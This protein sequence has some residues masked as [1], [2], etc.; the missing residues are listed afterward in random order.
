MRCLF[1]T[2]FAVAA[3]ASLTLAILLTLLW[4]VSPRPLLGVGGRY[5]L[6]VQP[7]GFVFHMYGNVPYVGQSFGPST[8]WA[9]GPLFYLYAPSDPGQFERYV[10]VSCWAVILIFLVLP[11]IWFVMYRRQRLISHRRRSGLCIACGYDLRASVDRCPE[12][13]AAVSTSTN[14]PRTT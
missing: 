4:I 3:A 2:I 10:R 11:G 14:A 1:H 8:G 7:N 6:S 9:F 13:G 5:F 12:C